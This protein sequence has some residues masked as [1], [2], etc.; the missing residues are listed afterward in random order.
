MG[1]KNEQTNSEIGQ[2]AAKMLDDLS[3][4]G[5]VCLL[6]KALYGLRQAGR[7]WNQKLNQV[8]LGFGAKQ[9]SADPCV[10]YRG[11]KENLLLIATYVD[12]IL[13]ASRDKRIIAKLKQY[14]P[15]I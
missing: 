15:G 14:L 8:L 3:G 12:D 2:K 11:R 9:S 4:E 10:Y 6:N 1:Q 5:K 7:C 13:V